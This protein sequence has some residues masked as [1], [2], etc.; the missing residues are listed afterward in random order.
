MK[1]HVLILS[2]AFLVLC[3]LGGCRNKTIPVPGTEQTRPMES[4]FPSTLPT[5]E[6]TAAADETNAAEST[7]ST[8]PSVH[9]VPPEELASIE[10][11]I[12]D[13]NG[14]IRGQETIR[15]PR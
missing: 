10:A 15:N 5:A 4:T 8:D 3:L 12:E 6:S 9:T 1:K 13:G 11:T 2:A 7:G 14:P